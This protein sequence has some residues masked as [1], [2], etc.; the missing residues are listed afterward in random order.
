MEPTDICDSKRHQSN[1]KPMYQIREYKMGEEE[2]GMGN[3]ESDSGKEVFDANA[4][5]LEMISSNELTKKEGG[6]REGCSYY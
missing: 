3:E 1:T 6:G 4:S 5:T 2:V